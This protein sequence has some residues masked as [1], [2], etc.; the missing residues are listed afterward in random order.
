V[1]AWIGLG[2][3]QVDQH[4]KEDLKRC[5]G[6]PKKKRRIQDARKKKPALSTDEEMKK[7]RLH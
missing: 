5:V 7:G 3:K 6:N 2:R 4:R 1:R